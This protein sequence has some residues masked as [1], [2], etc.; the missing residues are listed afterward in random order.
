MPYKEVQYFV[1]TAAAVAFGAMGCARGNS[2]TSRVEPHSAAAQPTATADNPN[3][4]DNP[5]FS[6]AQILA[7]LDEASVAD[8]TA[9]AFAMTKATNEDVKNFAKDMMNDHHELRRDAQ[10]VASKLNLIPQA[11]QND[12]V[13]R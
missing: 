5:T 10:E 7:L 6:D 8:S 11:P 3:Y 1:I 2:S 9:A 13:R 4:S 12:P